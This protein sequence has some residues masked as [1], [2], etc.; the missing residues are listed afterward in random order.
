MKNEYGLDIDYFESLIKRELT[1]LSRYKPDEFARA[2]LRMAMTACS[3]T[4]SEPEFSSEIKA[5]AVREAAN[6][7][8]GNPPLNCEYDYF[9]DYANKLERGEL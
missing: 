1:D 8:L 5:E 7:I 4:L 3:D 6:E 9:M 2:C